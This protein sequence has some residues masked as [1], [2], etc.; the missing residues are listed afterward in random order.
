[1][2]TWLFPEVIFLYNSQRGNRQ[3]Y[4][5]QALLAVPETAWKPLDRLREYAE[6]CFV[7]T[8]LCTS[9]R[10]CEFRYVATREALREQEVLPGSPEK[11]YPFPVE[12][13]NKQRYKIHAVVTNRDISAHEPIYWYYKRCG[14]NEEVHTILKNELS[15]GILSHQI[16]LAKDKGSD[17]L[18]IRKMNYEHKRSD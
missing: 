8:G 9:K 1:L 6:V 3:G 14:H 4:F 11:E 12:E 16:N 5:H 10:G 18:R 15:G 17:I 2:Y 7:P 13:M